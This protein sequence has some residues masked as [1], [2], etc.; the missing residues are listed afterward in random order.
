MY[1]F[2]QT[3]IIHNPSYLEP[4]EAPPRVRARAVSASEMEVYW[5]PI[6]PGS[7]IEKII[8]YEV[9]RE[10]KVEI[11]RNIQTRS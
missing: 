11:L 9:R 3:C 7:S 4:S 6:P 10:K 1:A 8:A 2:A 5:E